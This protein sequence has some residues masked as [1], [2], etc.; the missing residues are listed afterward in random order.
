MSVASRQQLLFKTPYWGVRERVKTQV[1]Q[2]EALRYLG[3]AGQAVDEALMQR[4]RAIAHEAQN[5]LQTSYVWRVFAI[6]PHETRWLSND[7]EG[8]L[9]QVALEGSTLR[10]QGSSINRHLTG[11]RAVALLAC[12]LGHAS[13]RE[14]RARN[15]LDPTNA[16]FYSAA[17]SSL[18]EAGADCAQ[19]RISAFAQ[20]HGLFAGARFSPGYGDLPLDTQEGFA[21]E[22]ELGRT[23]GVALTPEHLLIPLKS[24]TAII[25]LYDE[26]PESDYVQSCDGCP[27][28]DACTYREKG[29]KCYE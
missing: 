24:I 19:E 3:Y 28:R 2:E 14:L 21:R 10:L 5:T 4:F 20:D 27:A 1:N 23:L 18:V 7:Q 15:A 16:L 17:A 29:L 26:E 22:L 12:T 13:E 9:P 6:D 11:A 8:P 25:G